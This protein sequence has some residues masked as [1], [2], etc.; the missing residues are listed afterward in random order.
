MISM[1]SI[2]KHGRLGNQMFQYASL[3]GI[4]DNRG[5]EC[6]IPEGYYVNEKDANR[7]F[8]VFKINCKK[9]CTNFEIVKESAWFDENLFQNCTDQVDLQ[10]YF[11]SEKY[12]RNISSLIKKEYQFKDQFD[13]PNF[14]Y[15]TIHV[16]RGD[17]VHQ[18]QNHP[19]SS[20]EYYSRAKDCFKQGMKFLV[21]SDDIEWC[22][23]Q[24]F[25]GDCEFFQG[26]ND[27]HE[28]FVMTKSIGNI[29]ANSTF[30][31]WGAWLNQNPQNVVVAPFQ[32]FGL[33]IPQYPFDLIPQEWIIL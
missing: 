19:V 27:I 14:D 10:G 12:F 1:N 8:D 33:N 16:R 23:Q 22:K 13:Y 25:F 24:E 30:S 29:I 4:A 6:I 3:K 32:W 18:P 26:E 31:W 2:G 5:F 21:V 17:Y 9:G 15:V 11:Q 20:F 28:L 7:L